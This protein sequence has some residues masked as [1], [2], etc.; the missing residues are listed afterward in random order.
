MCPR[1]RPLRP[2]MLATRWI[3]W[4]SGPPAIPGVIRIPVEIHWSQK[5]WTRR[6]TLVDFS[7]F[8]SATCVRRKRTSSRTVRTALTLPMLNNR[9]IARTIGIVLQRE[10]RYCYGKV[11]RFVR[12]CYVPRTGVL[13]EGEAWG[14]SRPVIFGRFR[15][16]G[17]EPISAGKARRRQS[18]RKSCAPYKRLRGTS[19][20][21]SPIRPLAGFEVWG[22]C[23]SPN[24][25]AV[26][27]QV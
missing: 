25:P 10:C 5:I 2:S 7:Y 27:I 17:W 24:V 12:T 20:D 21:E 22:V 4:T 9:N 3:K 1:L 8:W 26:L 15:W 23:K 19:W 14:G 13:H 16:S 18:R 11:E 6:R